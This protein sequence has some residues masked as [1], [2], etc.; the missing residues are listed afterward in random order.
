MDALAQ[1][2]KAQNA[3][4]A[5]T[6]AEK[7]QLK[8]FAKFSKAL[9]SSMPSRMARGEETASSMNPDVLG[10]LVIQVGS[11]SHRHATSWRLATPTALVK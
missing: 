11:D 7:Q 1:L 8:E 5:L 4:K 3:N 6:M 9:T 10:C 2:Q